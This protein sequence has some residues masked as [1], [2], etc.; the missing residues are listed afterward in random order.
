MKK[1][2]IHVAHNKIRAAKDSITELNFI[3]AA[4]CRAFVKVILSTLGDYDAIQ[5]W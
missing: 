5:V 3:E 2:Y 4:Q 1:L